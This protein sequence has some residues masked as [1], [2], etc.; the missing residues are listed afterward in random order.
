MDNFVSP[1]KLLTVTAPSTVTANQLL[2]VGTNLFGVVQ[3]DA[4]SGA[5][6][7]LALEG[8]FEVPADVTNTVAAVGQFATHHTTNNAISV[9]APG[10]GFVKVGV[11]T[12]AKLT[13]D[14]TVQVRLNGAF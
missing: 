2:V 10:A 7:V 12:R 13:T 3:N 9:T 11:F 4:A 14:T 5:Q 1:G 6:V 8:V